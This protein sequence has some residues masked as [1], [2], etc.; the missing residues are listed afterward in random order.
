MRRVAIGLAVSLV[1]LA[2]GCGRAMSAHESMMRELIAVGYETA[3]VLATITDEASANAAKP[4]LID[5]RD[6]KY[7]LRREIRELGPPPKD[8]EE[9]FKDEFNAE[10]QKIYK[11]VKAETKRI[12][13]IPG[14][15][16]VLIDVID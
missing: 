15:R 6:R 5:L 11:R 13:S 10:D 8:L 4:K 12:K 1:L 7:G 9:R 2:S 16:R 3:D 14:T